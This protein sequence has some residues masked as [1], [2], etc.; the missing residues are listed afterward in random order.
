[1]R[2][3]VCPARLYNVIGSLIDEVREY[4]DSIERGYTGHPDV[5]RLDR[6]IERAE[7]ARRP[8]EI[9]GNA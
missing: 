8:R 5:A 9:G 6:L 7:N 1:M 2:V 3:R 4:R